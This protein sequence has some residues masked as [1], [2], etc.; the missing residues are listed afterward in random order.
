MKISGLSNVAKAFRNL[1]E[2]VMLAQGLICPLTLVFTTD[3]G[4]IPWRQCNRQ[5]E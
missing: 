2:R 4:V 5:P 3:N 1:R